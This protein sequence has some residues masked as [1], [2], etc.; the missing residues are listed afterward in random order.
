MQSV[1][2]SWLEG[3]DGFPIK[4]GKSNIG[5]GVFKARRSKT[6]DVIVDNDNKNTTILKMCSSEPLTE[7]CATEVHTQHVKQPFN[8]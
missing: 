3:F 7:V 6:S 8:Q 4:I 2:T 5:S 1:G